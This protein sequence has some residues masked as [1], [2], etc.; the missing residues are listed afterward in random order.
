MRCAVCVFLE[1]WEGVSPSLCLCMKSGSHIGLLIVF[2]RNCSH[3]QRSGTVR[4]ASSPPTMRSIIY[5][6]VVC[7]SFTTNSAAAHQTVTNCDR[8][9][10][11]Q[12][13]GQLQT[14]ASSQP[15]VRE[16]DRTGSVYI[17]GKGT[18]MTYMFEVRQEPSPAASVQSF[19]LFCSLSM[20]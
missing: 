2:T 8:Y 5:H 1:C 15:A 10:V 3:F 14:Q 17:Q 11:P 12:G 18:V 13:S 16:D 6:C 19:Y 20:S 4:D 7:L 9:F